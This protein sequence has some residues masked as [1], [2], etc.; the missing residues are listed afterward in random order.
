VARPGA[1]G[2][3]PAALLSFASAV[4]YSGYSIMTRMLARSDSSETTL[5]YSNLVGAVVTSAAVPFFW[6]FPN[7]PLIVLLM[8]GM[9]VFS[10][11]GHYMLIVAHRHA[12]A[13]VLAP[14]IYTE[15]VWMIALGY[16]VFHDVPNHW[17]LAGAAVV[18][19][20]GLYLIYRERKVR[21]EL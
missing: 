3:H 13:G 10:G 12:P 7:E 5:F 16:L 1:G 20:S 19:G 21:A 15:I 9:G 6:T 17:T 11:V 14:F 4:C 18:V 2:I 8:C